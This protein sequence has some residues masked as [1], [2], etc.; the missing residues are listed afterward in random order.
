M[1]QIDEFS[2][3]VSPHR[4]LNT[5]RGVAKFGR[6]AMGMSNEEFRDA[7]N[8]SPRNT[9]M[10]FV[11]EAYRA[12][13]NKNSRKQQTGTFF[14]RFQ[15]T[16]LAKKNT[17]GLW[18]VLYVP[19]PRRCF[20]C[21]KSGHDSKI[22]RAIEEVCQTCATLGHSKDTCPYSDNPNCL[23]CKGPHTA[24]SRDCPRFVTEKAALQIQE[25][26]NCSLVDARK[27]VEQTSAT[28]N[29]EPDDAS[30]PE[31]HIS[32]ARSMAIVQ[33]DLI[34]HNLTLIVENAR[35]R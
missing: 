11:A 21:Q 25:E 10:P 8:F 14:L 26:S 16:T 32:Y 35:L 23:N 24:F 1:T 15:V 31:Q 33:V 28:T 20:R 12:S 6:A 13:V 27:Q 18:T 17:A 9:D 5:R 30:T 29:T 3:K 4:S 34:N 22:C 19:S 2:V 7:L